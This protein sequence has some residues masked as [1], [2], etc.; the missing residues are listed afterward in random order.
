MKTNGGKVAIILGNDDPDWGASLTLDASINGRSLH[1]P[2]TNFYS[3]SG[4][5]LSVNQISI[6]FFVFSNEIFHNLITL[7]DVCRSM[8]S[9]IH[10]Y[11]KSTAQEVGRFYNEFWT[12]VTRNYAWETGLRIRLSEEWNKRE[13]GNF[14]YKVRDLMSLGP[15]DERFT[16]MV[17][18]EPKRS[19]EAT[20]AAP[21]GGNVDPK[22]VPRP[23][24]P[25]N[26][27]VDEQHVVF[28]QVSFLY[29]NSKRERIL[30]IINHGIKVSCSL[31]EI[32][33]SADYTAIGVALA[34]RSLGFFWDA[35]YSVVDINNN[36]VQAARKLYHY[37]NNTLK[38]EGKE[39]SLAM[40]PMFMLGVIKHP[41]FNMHNLISSFI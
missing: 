17:E 34:K 28:I 22:A 11:Q 37:C 6:D 29:T 32:Y 7:T 10:Y 26:T 23:A 25:R 1:L 24:S 33:E 13:Y 35:K 16:V 18:L 38:Q 9:E 8:C 4:N 20:P 21:A 19:G 12:F 31:S 30:R 3:Q 14:H 27:L 39:N 41:I 5:I 40:L 36:I 15:V 2:S